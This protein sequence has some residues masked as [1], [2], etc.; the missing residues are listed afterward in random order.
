MRRGPFDVDV[1]QTQSLH[2][3]EPVDGIGHLIGTSSPAR[4]ASASHPLAASRAA[5]TFV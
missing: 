3:V 2:S 1:F 4:R 5:S